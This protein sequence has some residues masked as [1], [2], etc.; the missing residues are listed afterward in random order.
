MV[1]LNGTDSPFLRLVIHQRHDR[2]LSY[3]PA[4]SILHTLYSAAFL[5]VQNLS[6]QVFRPTSLAE[7]VLAAE[8]KRLLGNI[9]RLE[10]QAAYGTLERFRRNGPGAR[11]GR[12]GFRVGRRRQGFGTGRWRRG[13]RKT[14]SVQRLGW[15]FPKFVA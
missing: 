9:F 6:F 5:L 3:D 13:R 14:G 4:A 11:F 8:T 12:R 15:F 7:P 10:I 2:L 1:I